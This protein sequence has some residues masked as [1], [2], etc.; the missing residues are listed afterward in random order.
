MNIDKNSSNNMA[1]QLNIFG[2]IN[3]IFGIIGIL[4][5]LCAGFI[6]FS[7]GLIA[8]TEEPEAL[9]ILTIVGTFVVGLVTLISLPAILG[10][11]GLLRRKSW[12]RILMIIL[13]ALNILNIPIGTAIGAYGLWIL[14]NEET[15]YLLE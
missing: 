4:G 15:K 6:I 14:L 3:I 9:G 12:A 7:S 1:Q 8:A 13:S 5:G 2:W 11:W 10:G